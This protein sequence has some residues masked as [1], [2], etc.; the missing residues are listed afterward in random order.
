[1]FCIYFQ[2]SGGPNEDE[3]VYY[4]E[5]KNKVG[6]HQKD[7]NDS[8]DGVEKVNHWLRSYYDSSESDLDLLPLCFREDNFARRTRGGYRAHE[9]SSKRNHLLHPSRHN[10]IRVNWGLAPKFSEH[11]SSCYHDG[12]CH[13]T[14]CDRCRIVRETNKVPNGRQNKP[15]NAHMNKIRSE[16]QSSDSALGGSGERL[17]NGRGGRIPL[18]AAEEAE[19]L[20]DM[21][22]PDDSASGVPP[23][24]PYPDYSSLTSDKHQTEKTE[25]SY[26]AE[27][28]HIL[29]EF[30]GDLNEYANI[31]VQSGPY[32]KVISI[33]DV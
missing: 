17:W 27:L 29:K 30:E 9:R 25:K 14:N 16:S 2:D 21:I 18:L 11:F 12:H 1:M 10:E 8:D 22:Q 28:A 15:V 23:G 13:T 33:G 3:A 6:L 26:N 19:M 5:H 4:T 32:K 20:Q 24:E 7:P 31:T